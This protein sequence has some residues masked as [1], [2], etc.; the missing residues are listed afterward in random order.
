[1]SGVQRWLAQVPLLGLA[2]GCGAGIVCAEFGLPRWGLVGVVPLVLLAFRGGR[3]ALAL[4]LL[5]CLGMWGVHGA[6]LGVLA[7]A[8]HQLRPGPGVE[9]EVVVREVGGAGGFLPEAIADLL[10]GAG[11]GARLG[12]S[13]LPEEVLPG[14]RLQ[15]I[16]WVRATNQ[17]R[18]PGEL[19]RRAWLRRNGLAGEFRVAEVRGWGGVAPRYWLRRAAWRLRGMVRERIGLGL[20]AEGVPASLI[21]ALVLGERDPKQRA[22]FGDFRL[23]GTMHVFAVSGLH[24]GMI[25]VFAMGLLRLLRVPRREAIWAVLGIIWVYALVTGLRPPAMRAAL[26]ASV[27]LLGFVVRRA[28]MLGNSLLASVPLVL[29]VDSFQWQQPGF[30]LSYLVVAAIIVI[31]PPC[32][33]RLRPALQGDPFLPRVLYTR[34]QV[35]GRWVREKVGSLAVVSSAA[36]LGSMPLVWGH[37][38]LVTPVAIF[39]SLLLMPLVF[40]M[41]GGVMMGL[42]VGLICPPAEAILNQGAGLLASGAHLVARGF[43]AIP[44]SHFELGE[45]RWWGEGLLIFDLR[46]GNGAAYFGGARGVLID[47]G[48]REEFWRV[49]FPALRQTGAKPDS[50]ILS[51]PDGGH[52][53]GSPAALTIWSPEQVLLPVQE[54]LSPSFREMR[55]MAAT[56]DVRTVLA[57]S[58]QRFPLARGAELEIIYAAERWEG[59]LADDRCMVVRLHWQGWK[60]LMTNDAGFEIEQRLLERGVDLRSDLWIMGRN[61]GD[62]TGSERFV[63]AVA[64]AVIVATEA[65]FPVEERI[66]EHWAD[67]VASE[68]II[69]WRQS[70]TGAVAVEARPG[71]LELRSYLE[72]G[73]R[74]VLRKP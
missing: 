54:A 43:T 35:A 57:R 73:R 65:S 24:V 39:A 52:C 10:G 45:E 40:L 51:H 26:M 49:V 27:L 7:A 2:L 44:G 28:P 13:G 11:A 5:G 29:L 18:N 1:M 37:F 66:P 23:S 16:G 34:S 12:V 6:R 31:A 8:E 58:G 69:L 15:L 71:Q 21:R 36:W 22:V 53:G 9:I 3:V 67:W 14:D 59:S 72:A 56:E 38:G 4:A 33:R 41:L 17:I 68:G 62:F 19:D 47:T 48:G 42:L 50:L 64:P 61:Q 46:D 20:D 30:Q 63:R 25:G 60:V 55:K 70:E 74:E 32:F